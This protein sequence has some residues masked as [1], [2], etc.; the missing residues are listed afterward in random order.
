MVNE[1]ICCKHC[2]STQYVKAGKFVDGRQ[3]YKCKNCQSFFLWETKQRKG[4]KP[5]PDNI[6]CRNCDSVNLIRAGKSPDGRQMYKCKDCNF[7]MTWGGVKKAA[8]PSSSIL[9]SDISGITCKKCKSVNIVKAGL[10]TDGRQ[11][12]RCKTCQCTFTWETKVRK[13]IIVPEDAVCNKCGKNTNVI[14]RGK[15]MGKQLFYCKDCGISF[16]Y[17]EPEEEE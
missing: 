6:K 10:R 16:T 4:N 11:K 14:G 13:K 8:K 12:Y 7:V 17:S 15:N 5:I 2:G 9:P 1:N 3:R